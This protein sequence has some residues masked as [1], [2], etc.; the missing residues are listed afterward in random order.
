MLLGQTLYVERGRAE[1]EREAGRQSFLASSPP[2]VLSVVK[3]YDLESLR[4]VALRRGEETR[5]E[6]TRREEQRRSRVETRRAEE[7]RG[8]RATGGKRERRRRIDNR[9]LVCGRVTGSL[10]KVLECGKSITVL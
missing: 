1:R 3:T 9:D 6:E 7:G 2:R 8:V 5:G 4:A 10:E